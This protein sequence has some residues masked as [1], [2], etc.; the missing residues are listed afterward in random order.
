MEGLFWPLMLVLLGIVFLVLE[1]FIPSG[2]ALGVF[3]GLSFLG[4]IV[5]AYW[6]NSYAGASTLLAVAVIIPVFLGIF[7][8]YWPKT[9]IGKQVLLA[10][11]PDDAATHPDEEEEHLRTLIGKRGRAKSKMLPSGAVV[12]DNRVYDA[13]T[14]GLPLDPG[15]PVEVISTSFHRLIVRAV[16]NDAMPRLGG[17]SPDLTQPPKDL[18]L[19]PFEDPLL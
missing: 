13:T 7:V 2:G 17:D 3:A 1:M 18:D 8:H 19:S 4:A 15:Q 11:D 14:E 6:H 12:I 9:P 16:E 10:R 5:L